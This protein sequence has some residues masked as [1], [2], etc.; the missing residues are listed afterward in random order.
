M[1]IHFA[2]KAAFEN[3]VDKTLQADRLQVDN[4][5]ATYFERPKLAAFLGI[6][7]EPYAIIALADG[8]EFDCRQLVHGNAR[9]QSLKA[10]LQIPQSK[11]KIVETIQ[12]NQDLDAQWN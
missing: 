4:L 3:I 12:A 5:L 7:F 11:K 9:Q 6:V 8:G 1:F 2:S 10:K